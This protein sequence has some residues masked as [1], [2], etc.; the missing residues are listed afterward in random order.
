MRAKEYLEINK[1]SIKYLEEVSKV[2]N[3]LMP[4]RCSKELTDD[5]FNNVLSA[6]I[7]RQNYLLQKDLYEKKN[8]L[9]L[10]YLGIIIDT[11]VLRFNIESNT[12]Q[13]CFR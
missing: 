10:A 9:R 4:L 2:I 7:R 13:L 5:Y 1:S 11:D 3:Q 12:G 6:D 8:I